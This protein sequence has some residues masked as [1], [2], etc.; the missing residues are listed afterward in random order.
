EAT[1]QQMLT[2]DGFLPFLQTPAKV[3]EC[4]PRARELLAVNVARSTP[5]TVPAR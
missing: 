2:V 3:Q 1:S 5:T 4:R